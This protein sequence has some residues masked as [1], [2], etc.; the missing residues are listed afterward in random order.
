[1]VVVYFFIEISKKN[2]GSKSADHNILP[3]HRNKRHETTEIKMIYCSKTAFYAKCGCKRIS[4][5]EKKKR[6]TSIDK[7]TTSTLP[8]VSKP[9]LLCN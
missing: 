8:F 7:E 1:M 2:V 3:W 6:F 4:V 9:I 5:T